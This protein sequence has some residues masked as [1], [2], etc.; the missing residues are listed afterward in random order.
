[1]KDFSKVVIGTWPLSGDL[2]HVDKRNAYKIL[3]YCAKVG[4]TEF[5]TAPNYGQ[6]FVESCLGDVFGN[7]NDILINTKCGNSVNNIKDFGRTALCESLES[8]IR[9]L[10]RDSVHNLFL[11]NPRAELNDYEPVFDFFQREKNSGRITYGGLSAAKNYNYKLSQYKQ[12]D[13]LQDDANLLSLDGMLHYKTE[14]HCFYARSPLATGI[15]SGKMTNKTTFSSNDYRSTWL[16]GNR[17][18][19]IIKRVEVIRSLTKIELPS[20]A[21]RFMLQFKKVD[22]VI[23]GLKSIQ[24]VDDL[25]KDIEADQI[26][27]KLIQQIIELQKND[28]GLDPKEK[29]LGY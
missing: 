21:R 11:H 19:S 25:V 23:F 20:L 5:D 8:S 28:F 6:G 26:D 12:M 2:G 7:D 1:M 9:R 14:N 18:K 4:F 13:A 3:E 10:Q 22:K 27:N 15:L 29:S 24:H 17:L 16:K